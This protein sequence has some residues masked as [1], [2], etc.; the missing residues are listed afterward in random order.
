[1]KGF[2][3]TLK[4]AA[5]ST[6]CKIYPEKYGKYVP[7]M[8]CFCCGKAFPYRGLQDA[9]SI[10][11]LQYNAE[12]GEWAATQDNPVYCDDCMSIFRGGPYD[13]KTAHEVTDEQG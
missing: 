11:G 6:V 1:M 8:T 3:T 5:V 9:Y 13:G 7:Q 12:T 4:N 10:S 2:L